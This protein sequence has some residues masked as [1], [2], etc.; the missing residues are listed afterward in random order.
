MPKEIKTAGKRFREVMQA[1]KSL[2]IVGTVSAYQ[3]LKK[4]AHRKV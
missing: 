1:E 3:T 2:Q 4:K